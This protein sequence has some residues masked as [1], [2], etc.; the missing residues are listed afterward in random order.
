M[1]CGAEMK[2]E[3]LSLVL[4]ELSPEK[5]LEAERHLAGC[6]ECAALRL[7]LLEEKTQ[8]K[9]G[10]LPLLQAGPDFAAGVTAAAAGG[11]VRVLDLAFAGL[12][13]AAGFAALLVF[14]LPPERQSPLSPGPSLTPAFL[15][16]FS[17]SVPGEASGTDF[18]YR[19]SDRAASEQG[20]GPAPINL[21]E[22]V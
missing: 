22:G 8:L 12:A 9:T 21:K 19:L 16:P 3:I 7:A 5:V 11:K 17:A 4:G 2:R 14:G 20:A 18:L 1:N 10:G 13:L 15:N 6:P